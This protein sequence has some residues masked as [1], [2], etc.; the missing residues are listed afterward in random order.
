MD[1]SAAKMAGK[2]RPGFVWVEM[3]VTVR[4][5]GPV[6]N[7]PAKTWARTIQ[8]RIVLIPACWGPTLDSAPANSVDNTG[9]TGHRNTAPLALSYYS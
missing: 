9:N 8:Y 4:Y 6:Q 1:T 7:P 2:W 3:G 5:H